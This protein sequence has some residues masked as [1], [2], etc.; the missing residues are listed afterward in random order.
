MVGYYVS[1][2]VVFDAPSYEIQLCDC[3]AQSFK[4]YSFRATEWI[5]VFL[6][7]PD[8]TGLVGHVY[9]ELSR[10]CIVHNTRLFRVHCDV[11]LEIAE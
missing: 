11:P 9:R 2:D 8:E 4:L 6:G 1:D 10:L 7:I 5:K 3:C